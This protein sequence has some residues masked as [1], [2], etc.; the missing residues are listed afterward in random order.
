MKP[1]GLEQVAAAKADGRWQRAYASPSNVSVPKDFLKA[2][3]KDKKAKMFFATLDKTNTYAIVWRLETAT[4]PEVR[5]K[6]MI[7]ILAM[8]AKGESFHPRKSG[9]S[10][11]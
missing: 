8:L 7:S 2:L 4:T 9:S 5:Q 3:A 11:R 6:R 1:A 10:K